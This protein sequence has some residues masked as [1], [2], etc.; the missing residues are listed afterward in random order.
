MF[1]LFSG[2]LECPDPVGDK[3]WNKRAT[4]ETK[5]FPIRDGNHVSRLLCNPSQE[6]LGKNAEKPLAR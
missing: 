4:L 3:E 5:G 1:P 2:R 6:I